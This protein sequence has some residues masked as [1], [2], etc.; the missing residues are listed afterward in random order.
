M[1]HLKRAIFSMS[2]FLCNFCL[3]QSSTLDAKEWTDAQFSAFHKKV[4]ELA[5]SNKPELRIEAGELLLASSDDPRHMNV[6]AVETLLHLLNDTNSDVV[7]MA[8]N[9]LQSRL[10]GVNSVIEKEPTT[11][12]KLILSL[13]RLASFSKAVADRS[14]ADLLA[15]ELLLDIGLTV[16]P[17]CEFVHFERKAVADVSLYIWEAKKRPSTVLIPLIGK[18]RA[19]ENQGIKAALLARLIQFKED[20][21]TSLVCAEYSKVLSQESG[22]VP[23]TGFIRFVVISASQLLKKR[24]SET[25]NP[26]LVKPL[27]ELELQ[28]QKI[29]SLGFASKLDILPENL[30]L[31][32]ILSINPR[33]LK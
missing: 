30:A 1:S 3:G 19:S 7:F 18:I 14:E 9:A 32:E 16:V 6:Y 11:G 13:Q 22:G 28:Y 24:P 5:T 20:K 29:Q 26:I 21:M 31:N 8:L 2:Y 27:T 25:V 33:A 4:Q 12:R 10:G 17:Y 23:T 15:N